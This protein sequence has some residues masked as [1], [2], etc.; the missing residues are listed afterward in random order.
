L[1]GQGEDTP[2]F[3]F[4]NL[5]DAHEP[6]YPPF[7]SSGGAKPMPRERVPRQDRTGWLLGRW[8]PS[9]HEQEA[10]QRLYRS[11]IRG[12]GI[13][14]ER[15]LSILEECRRGPD[16]VIVLTSDH[17][18]AFGSDR[19]LFHSHGTEEAL[20]RVPMYIR[21]PGLSS[22]SRPP[23]GWVSLIDIVPTLLRVIGAD[24]TALPSARAIQDVANDGWSRPV[25][26]YSTGIGMP[27]A[28]WV[29]PQVRQAIDGLR[30][31]GYQANKKVT[32]GPTAGVVETF[33]LETDPFARTNTSR[34]REWDAGEPL[35]EVL[36]FYE[37]ISASRTFAPG[38]PVERR[39]KSWGY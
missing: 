36:A 37:R 22:G 26:A 4:L 34:G 3:G 1:L 17:G 19:A 35:P 8:T 18:Q 27:R 24:T 31:V 9:S 33:D 12:L 13:R 21:A 32:V 15:I 7:S 11:A 39:L 10:L 38:L 6:Y 25:F 20:L 5:L 23:R 30:T 28:S 2:V 29:S 16:P 14:L